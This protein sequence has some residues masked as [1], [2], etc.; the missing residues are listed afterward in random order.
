M[1]RTELHNRQSTSAR[2]NHDLQ[3]RSRKLLIEVDDPNGNP[4]KIDYDDSG[5]V[6]STTDGLGKTLTHERSADLPR[7]DAVLVF[8]N[9]QRV[10]GGDQSTLSL[11]GDQARLIEA[12]AKANPATMVVLNTGGPVLIPWLDN[13]AGVIEAWYPGQE[14]GSA[15]ASVL[16]G[17][18]NPS[19]RL[20]ITFPRSEGRP[21]CPIP[22]AGRAK[23]R[24]PFTTRRS[25]SA[26]V[27]MMHTERPLCF[28]SDSAY[29]IPSS[30]LGRIAPTQ[31]SLRW[32]EVRAAA[33]SFFGW[34]Q[35]PGSKRGKASFAPS[36]LS[37]R[38][39]AR[40]AVWHFVRPSDQTSAQTP[41]TKPMRS[42]EERIRIDCAPSD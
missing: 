42:F 39:I 29:L 28:R 25:R 19:G 20:P 18:V 11:P 32:R 35:N 37:D 10:E 4:Q 26:T 2:R 21:R 38:G 8:V 22:N 17:D 9:D 3:I 16:F 30:P 33:K 1:T 40:R 15:I 23:T 6:I 7:A 31:T 41:T 5:R 12:V 24:S 14:S 27:G 13:V 34:A 36:G